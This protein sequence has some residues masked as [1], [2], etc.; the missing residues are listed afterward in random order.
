MIT[1]RYALAG[2]G[3]QAAALAFGGCTPGA[4]VACT[5]A[6]SVSFIPTK[7][8]NYSNT[9]GATILS[10]VSA[11]WNYANDTAAAAGGV[12]LGGLYRSGSFVLIRLV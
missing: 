2:A 8:F 4:V 1:A 6:Y 3:T 10:Q 7:T 12:P 5:E 9:T 11:S